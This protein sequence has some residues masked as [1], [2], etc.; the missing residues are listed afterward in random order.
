[1]SCQNKLRTL[2]AD[3]FIVYF[4]SH[5]YHLNVVGPDFH[6]Y[7]SLLN[8]IYDSLFEW[9]DTLNE[10][11]R[12]MDVMCDTSLKDYSHLTSF[13][14]DNKAKTGKDM[15]VDLTKAFESIIEFSQNLYDEAGRE[16]HGA[17]ETC[18]GDYMMDINKLHWKVKSCL[19]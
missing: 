7:H 17:L 15:F 6:Q 10:Q 5:A 16:G 12:Q 13:S 8:D 14:L 11:L 9:H 2:I 4:K 3:N 19:A 18:I 1:M